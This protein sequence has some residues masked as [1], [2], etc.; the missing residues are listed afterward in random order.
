MAIDDYLYKHELIFIIRD[1]SKLQTMNFINALLAS[2]LGSFFG[3]SVA[4]IY[5]KIRQSNSMRQEL[6]SSLEQARYIITLMR[7]NIAQLDKLR[8]KEE[9]DKKFHDFELSKRW[10]PEAHIPNFNVNNLLY[11]LDIGPTGKKI[12]DNILLVNSEY[13]TL[14][15]KSNDF[16]NLY[17]QYLD[18]TPDRDRLTLNEVQESIGEKL[19][20]EINDLHQN[21]N[22]L[23]KQF[24]E[25]SNTAICEIQS[26]EF[27]KDIREWRRH[28]SQK[29]LSKLV[30]N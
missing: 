6:L 30:C 17:S 19:F 15:I 8:N 2:M 12:L 28:W 23:I 22:K 26:E 7:K 18:K 27:K 29:F 13:N 24:L 11:M 3:A 9:K 16:N 10:D 1:I 25:D 4:F 14:M 20:H 21:I 5:D